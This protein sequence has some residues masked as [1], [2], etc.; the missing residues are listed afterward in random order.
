MVEANTTSGHSG[1]ILTCDPELPDVVTD[2]PAGGAPSWPGD[3]RGAVSGRFT[4]DI[5]DAVNAK[6]AVI[7]HHGAVVMANSLWSLAPDGRS[8]CSCAPV[9]EGENWPARLRASRR[10]ELID[11]ADRVTTVLDGRTS[12]ARWECPGDPTGT[13]PTRTVEVTA[14]DGPV[15]G[16]VVVQSDLTWQR[17]LAAELTH[18]ATHDELTGLL[19]RA[20]L[21][22]AMRSRLDSLHEHQKLAVLFCDL[23]GFK[24]VNDSLGHA[25]GDQVL[26]AVAW[27]LRQ[28]CRQADIVARFGGDEFVV[29]QPVLN[30]A[31]ARATADRLIEVLAEPI[32]VGDVDV[33]TGTS[34]GIVVVD[35]AP[36]GEDPV[37]ALL[38]DADTAMYHAKERGRRRHELFDAKLRHDASDRLR[39]ASLLN[40]AVPHQ[41]LHLKYQARRRCEDR[42]LVG[43]EALIRW[44]PDGIRDVPA[45]TFI[46][47][48]E[49]T[50]HIVRLG[51]WVLRQALADVAG[52]DRE[53]LSIAV[54]ISPRQ[55]GAPDLVDQVTAA[56]DASGIPP[57]Y[58]ILEI[59]EGALVDDPSTAQRVLTRLRDLG[60]GIALDDFGTGWSSLSYLRTLPVDVLKI[61]R[62]FVADLPHDP[63]ARAVA[64][65]V[66]G[67]GH[68][69]GLTVVAEGVE[70]HRQLEIL[71][72]MG[73]EEYQGFIDGQPGALSDILRDG[74]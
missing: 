47:I 23:D 30:V 19:N 48:A 37:G 54:N 18:R 43:V 25:V 26:V 32:R 29:V 73:C 34:I 59:T 33:A 7:D 31:Q 62:S 68:G 10:S 21:R 53:R 24:D 15:P 4:R 51:G 42:A 27:R 74:F 52:P 36:G 71:R 2:A 40:K 58:L 65:A 11:L 45:P 5:L 56:L 3:L 69:M 9:P 67:L 22:E 57:G 46:P 12:S 66:F 63:N 6:V 8:R 44:S 41:D 72:D 35:G 39:Y 14:L 17:R 28:R 64:A 60:V 13:E 50:G 20:A 1:R 38:R 55:L 61:D 70:N 16:A 49:R